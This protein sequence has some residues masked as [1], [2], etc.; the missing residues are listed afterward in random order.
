VP[1]DS[2]FH[3][4]VKNLE[5]LY[6]VHEVTVTAAGAPTPFSGHVEER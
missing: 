3:Q 2:Q 6:N 5:K 1:D 4:V